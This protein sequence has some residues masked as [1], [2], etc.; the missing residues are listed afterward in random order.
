MRK[1]R[2]MSDRRHRPS[3]TSSMTVTTG[4]LALAL[5][6]AGGGALVDTPTR[7]GC[8]PKPF[9]FE[10]DCGAMAGTAPQGLDRLRYMP[11]TSSGDWW[12]QLGSE[13]RFRTEYMDRLNY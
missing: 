8:S 7:T 3:R 9:R 10:E 13:Y 4:G 12:L 1:V 6:V 5:M 2:P 11:L